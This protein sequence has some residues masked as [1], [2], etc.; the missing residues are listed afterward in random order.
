MELQVGVKVLLRN[1]MGSFLLLRSNPEKY[2]EK[3]GRWDLPG[4]RINPGSSLFENLKR[5]VKEETSLNLLTE[6]KL[7]AAQDILKIS[8]RH[9]VRL[10]YVGDIQGEP[11]ID[12][13]SLKYKWFTQ[14]EIEGLSEHE[15]DQ[16]F[17]E[18]VYTGKVF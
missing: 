3:G 4:G 5:E 18:L 16:F 17:K 15:L 12:H 10:T 9:V 6:P 2:P 11:V 14:E 1:G 13:E 7:I 8:D